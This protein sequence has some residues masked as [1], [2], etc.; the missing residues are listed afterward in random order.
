MCMIKQKNLLIFKVPDQTSFHQ[1][2]LDQQICWCQT[3][4]FSKAL[5]I[6]EEKIDY[7]IAEKSDT[8]YLLVASSF[9][10]HS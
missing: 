3:A 8:E 9:K 5:Q 4:G 6:F 7:L 10:A 2:I 1:L